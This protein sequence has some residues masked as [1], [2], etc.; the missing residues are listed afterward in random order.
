MPVVVK[1]PDCNIEPVIVKVE[2]S[3]VKS[4]SAFNPVDDV[5]VITLLSAPLV[6]EVMPALV[7]VIP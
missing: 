1:L 7:P 4:D 3:N 2:P 5:A 6:N